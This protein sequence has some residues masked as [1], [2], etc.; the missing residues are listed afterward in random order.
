MSYLDCRV[1]VKGTISDNEVRAALVLEEDERAKGRDVSVAK[2]AALIKRS[3]FYKIMAE[4]RETLE[5]IGYGLHDKH[6]QPLK[7][8]TVHRMT[9]MRRKLGI[10]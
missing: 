1:A 7:L 8:K 4:S 9:H 3:V 5:R 6:L 10:G 2:I